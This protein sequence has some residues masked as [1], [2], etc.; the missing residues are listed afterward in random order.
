MFF[1]A[2]V[3]MKNVRRI[4]LELIFPKFRIA[5]YFQV[6][7]D[8]TLQ[9]L[10]SAILGTVCH[11]ALFTSMCSFNLFIENPETRLCC[12]LCLLTPL[13]P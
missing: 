9:R 8:D 3:H 1:V 12:I 2:F 13:L 6:H 10:T 4:L 5:E 7:V 11:I